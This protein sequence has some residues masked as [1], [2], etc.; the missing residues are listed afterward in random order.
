MDFLWLPTSNLANFKAKK[1]INNLPLFARS[2]IESAYMPFFRFVILGIT[3][4]SKEFA[5]KVFD[6]GE[7]FGKNI[8]DI[9]I[10]TMGNGTFEMTL[11]DMK[12]GFIENILRSYYQLL[13]DRKMALIF[14]KWG[15]KVKNNFK[16]SGETNIFLNSNEISTPFISFMITD[17]NMDYDYIS[18]QF[19]LSGVRAP[20]DFLN[21]IRVTGIFSEQQQ[22]NKNLEITVH[23]FIDELTKKNISLELK[24]EIMQLSNLKNRI[25]NDQDFENFMNILL[26]IIINITFPKA[27]IDFN[28]SIE[29]KSKNIFDYSGTFIKDLEEIRLGAQDTLITLI[30]KIKNILKFKEEFLTSPSASRKTVSILFTPLTLTNLENLSFKFDAKLFVEQ[31]IYEQFFNE[32]KEFIYIEYPNPNLSNISSI[33]FDLNG[34]SILF[35][36][37]EEYRF[38]NPEGKIKTYNVIFPAI[39]EIGTKP[40]DVIDSFRSKHDSPPQIQQQEGTVRFKSRYNIPNLKLSVEIPGDPLMYSNTLFID[41]PVFFVEKN[42]DLSQI[43]GEFVP[44]FPSS[45]F[46]GVYMIRNIE[47]RMGVGESYITRID[48]EKIIVKELLSLPEQ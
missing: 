46:S 21:S 12:P 2:K 23:D 7:I 48:M 4:N 29:N 47:H 19:K 40:K 18:R 43:T 20:F 10:N 3:P 1:K 13:H 27:N 9:T 25:T 14:I 38:I 35:L 44:I 24:N 45:P 37:S 17:V 8:V 34:T 26:R 33:S 6:S 32:N 22:E 5:E 36:S 42:L 39:T 30:D 16:L 28:F 31:K 11:V 15:W 41:M